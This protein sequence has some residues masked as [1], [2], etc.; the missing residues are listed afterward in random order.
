MNDLEARV[1][2]LERRQAYYRDQIRVLTALVQRLLQ[3]IGATS[4]A[5]YEG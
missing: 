4:S 2:H 5:R 3:M 1:R